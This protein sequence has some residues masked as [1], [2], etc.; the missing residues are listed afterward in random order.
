MEL[1][2]FPICFSRHY[3]CSSIDFYEYDQRLI[4]CADLAISRENLSAVADLQFADV[5]QRLKEKNIKVE[6]TSE[7]LDK[8]ALIGYDPMY[9]AT[10]RTFK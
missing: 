8:V 5:G 1:F 6:A 2:H 7:A 9:G 3:F 4:H 10:S